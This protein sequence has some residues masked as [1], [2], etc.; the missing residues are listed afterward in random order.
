MEGRPHSRARQRL[1]QPIPGAGRRQILTRLGCRARAQGDH[2]R[3]GGSAMCV[4]GNGTELT[5][6]G[7]SAMLPGDPDRMALHRE[8]ASIE[9]FMI[10]GPAECKGF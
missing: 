6:Y 7:G 3:R 8:N 9:S 5:S 2:A 4:S 10:D 1:Y